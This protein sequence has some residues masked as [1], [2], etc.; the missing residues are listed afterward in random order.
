MGECWVSRARMAPCNRSTLIRRNRTGRL[1]SLAAF[2]YSPA[3]V[4]GAI[5]LIA[6]YA[7][8][9]LGYRLGL[10][11]TVSSSAIAQV[12]ILVGGWLVWRALRRR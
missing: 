8:S 6:T 4:I 1:L 3:L 11:G 5:V 12:M 9:D 2:Q 10:A 7:N